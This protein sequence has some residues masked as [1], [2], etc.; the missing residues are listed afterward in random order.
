MSISV[1]FWLLAFGFWLLAVGV[2]VGVGVGWVYRVIRLCLFARL[3]LGLA[4]FRGLGGHG[5]QGI[6]FIGISGIGGFVFSSNLANLTN[7]WRR[8]N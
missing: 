1:G 7:E 4:V 6:F 5:L 2:G 8:L 3:M